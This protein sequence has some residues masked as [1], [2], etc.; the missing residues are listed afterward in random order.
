MD[1][2]LYSQKDMFPQ[3]VSNKLDSIVIDYKDK[4]KLI[5]NS[6]SSPNHLEAG[7]VLLINYKSNRNCSEYVFQLIK[8]S[9]TVTQAGDISCPGGIVHPRL[10]RII[11]Y[12]LK[13][14]I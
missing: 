4:H 7:V 14:G 1:F 9:N 13:T 3:F 8:R 12:L 5:A 2:S 10:D 6:K 11:S